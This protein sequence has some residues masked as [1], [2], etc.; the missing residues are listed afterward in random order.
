[1]SKRYMM[2]VRNFD[3]GTLKF[4]YCDVT[5]QEIDDAFT[6]H[7]RELSVG[8]VPF[9]VQAASDA[10]V[11]EDEASVAH[12]FLYLTAYAYDEG[13]DEVDLAG[14]PEFAYCIWKRIPTIKDWIIWSVNDLSVLCS[15]DEAESE[16]FPLCS[17]HE[18][19]YTKSFAQKAWQFM[20]AQR[21]AALGVR[22]DARS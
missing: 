1:M 13:S 6:V 15:K 11:L 12:G 4:P 5:R 7:L 10:I 17:D 19:V 21:I 8:E 16:L 3:N 14:R 2:V 18:R 20:V 22:N 9:F